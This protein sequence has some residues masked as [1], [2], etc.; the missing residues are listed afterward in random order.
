MKSAAQR[1]PV[2]TEGVKMGFL[3]IVVTDHEYTSRAQIRPG[4]LTQ[5]AGQQSL[6]INEPPLGRRNSAGPSFVRKG[7]VW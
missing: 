3:P 4:L 6:V 1:P 5:E 2:A 7:V